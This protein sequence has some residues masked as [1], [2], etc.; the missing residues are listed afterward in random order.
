MQWYPGRLHDIKLCDILHKS[1]DPSV[2]LQINFPMHMTCD[3]GFLTYMWIQFSR[4]PRCSVDSLLS[5]RP[6]D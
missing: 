4:L 1:P 2:E 6:H 3:K 5:L